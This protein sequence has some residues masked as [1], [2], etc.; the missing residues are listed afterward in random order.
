MANTDTYIR[1][2]EIIFLKELTVV[3][4][5]VEFVPNEW[6]TGIGTGWRTR[7]FPASRNVVDILST[8]VDNYLEWDFGRRE[9]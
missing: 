2:A 6:P 1:R 5:F 7:T 4:L 3:N 8:E 9:E